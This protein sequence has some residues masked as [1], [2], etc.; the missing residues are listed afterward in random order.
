MRTGVA[1]KAVFIDTKMSMLK[2]FFRVAGKRL[3]AVGEYRYLCWLGSW[4]MMLYVT[5]WMH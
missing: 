1:P 2:L 3:S 5:T 4:Y